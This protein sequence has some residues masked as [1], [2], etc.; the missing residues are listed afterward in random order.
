CRAALIGSAAEAGSQIAALHLLGVEEEGLAV[1]RR[2]GVELD[3]AQ[4]AILAEQ[5]RDAFGPHADAESLALGKL[6]VA[7]RLPLGAGGNLVAPCAEVQGQSDGSRAAPVGGE[8]LVAMFP[9]V[10]V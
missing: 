1:Q 3:A 9:A 6:F 10:T 2:S 5:S 8:M 7:R 4:L